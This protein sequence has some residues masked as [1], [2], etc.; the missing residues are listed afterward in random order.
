MTEVSDMSENKYARLQELLQGANGKDG[1]V[2]AMHFP[3]EKGKVC[4]IGQGFVPC[5]DVEVSA[6]NVKE[7]LSEGLPQLEENAEGIT[8]LEPF[9]RRERLIILGGGHIAVPL[10]MI[11][12]M[13]GFYV[14]VCDDRETFANGERFPH[15]D[16]VH[17]AS[18]ERCIAELKPGSSDYVVIV[19]RGHSHDAECIEAIGKYEEP[20]YTGL[21]GS[22][23]RVAMVFRNL[24]EQGYD[25]DRLH[26]ICTPIGLDIGAKT[27]EEIDIAIMAEIIKRRRKDSTGQSY[28]DRGDHN[29]TD[30]TEI[31]KIHLPCAVATIMKDEG[32]T[33]R[34]AGARMAIFVDGTTIGSIGGGCVE[35][36]IIHT[37][38][39]LVDTG[40]Y[41]IV[42]VSL[43]ATAAMEEGMVCGGRLVVLIEDWT[44]QY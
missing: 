10:S 34:A 1:V 2:Y 27:I 38:K 16:E 37:A 6:E 12:K 19:T 24:I 25:E 11:A 18:F 28:I 33:P 26:R 36:E 29:M 42:R 20:M 9:Y 5:G 41:E 7:V 4:D 3:A 23:R 21:I 35:G 13:T 15:A 44:T 8:F 22:R 39:K 31:G 40:Q 17:C 14:V 32:S 30:I 43:D